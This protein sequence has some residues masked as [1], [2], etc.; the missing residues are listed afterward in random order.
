MK[1]LI[2]AFPFSSAA[3]RVWGPNVALVFHRPCP[4]LEAAPEFD[5]N[6]FSSRYVAPL[7]YVAWR[8][9]FGCLKPGN[10]RSLMERMNPATILPQLFSGN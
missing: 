7:Q 5:A 10:A 9:M 6:A 4:K 1:V 3:I 8:K 2:A